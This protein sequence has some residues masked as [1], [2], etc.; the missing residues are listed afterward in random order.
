MLEQYPT[1]EQKPQLP[2]EGVGLALEKVLDNTAEVERSLAVHER[3]ILEN[4]GGVLDEAVKE[5]LE[6]PSFKALAA[7]L[8]FCAATSANV[9]ASASTEVG[10]LEP[11]PENQTTVTQSAPRAMQNF[12]GIQAPLDWQGLALKVG[13]GQEESLK[14]NF[15][16]IGTVGHGFDGVKLVIDSYEPVEASKFYEGV[17]KEEHRSALFS[18]WNASYASKDYA[19][20]VNKL[21]SAD[22][23]EQQKLIVLQT[24][25]AY[26]NK[27]YNDDMLANKEH[28]VVS[29][30]KMFEGIKSFLNSKDG[31]N[32]IPTGICGNIHTTLVKTA[33]SFGF[34]AWLQGG[35]VRSKDFAAA[36]HVWAGLVAKDGGGKEQ[37]VFLD[38]GKII[39]TG[40]LNYEDALGVA[41]RRNQQIL[42]FDS[43]VGSPEG[44]LVPVKSSAQKSVETASGITGSEHILEEHLQNEE[45]I[46]PEGLGLSVSNTATEV[47]F[48]KDM[49]AFAFTHMEDKQNNPYQSLASMDALRSSLRFDSKHVGVDAGV[50]L[51]N[52]SLKDLG[53]GAIAQREVIGNLG[54]DFINSHDFTKGEYE[55]FVVRYG[56]SIEAGMRKILGEK[57]RDDQKGLSG[58]ML[59]ATV[60]AKVLYTDPANL[61]TVYVGVSDTKRKQL[62]DFED[63][64]VVTQD[65]STKFEVGAN[66]NV[67]EGAVLGLEASIADT[68]Y[69]KKHTGQ[70]ALSGSH[71]GVKVEGEKVVS[72]M[73][74][75]IPSSEKV[76]AEVSYRPAAMPL[77][78]IS[79]FGSVK[80][81]Q[82]KGADDKDYQVGI[83][84]RILVW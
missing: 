17:S 58:G 79:V 38:Y 35:V 39:P 68:E 80:N 4:A 63:Q 25:G 62:S 19:S 61:G 46:R 27:T 21:G 5:A 78:E 59:E 1:P 75:F 52:L 26:L 8:V 40:T 11:L 69:G 15:E 66:V 12:Q 44:P 13:G 24:L 36:G 37:I 30:G 74:R 76:S 48:S 14:N 42:V 22:L 57:T 20:F 73:E 51:L 28:V 70:V 72:E 29:D 23:N 54:L 53:N 50:T 6:K 67:Y 77:A 43:Y 84:A 9:E 34:E 60:G 41:E 82:Y 3:E 47:T 71:V 2:E 49:L 31:K 16:V 32:I 18:L 33:T 83:K 64:R 56:A 65:V 81:E 45:I 10:A 55:R 7:A